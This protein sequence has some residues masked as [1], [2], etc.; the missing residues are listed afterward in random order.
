MAKRTM[1]TRLAMV[2]LAAMVGAACAADW[3]LSDVAQSP[4]RIPDAQRARD[5]APEQ[6]ITVASLSQGA[7]LEPGFARASV[8]PTSAVA[9]VA[10]PAS[11]VPTTVGEDAGGLPA[12][13]LSRLPGDP[14]ADLGTI[15]LRTGPVSE[16]P[17]SI[18]VDTSLLGSEFDFPEPSLAPAPPA[19]PAFD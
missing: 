9:I 11:Q 18:T 6:S 1:A 4:V 15:E 8:E 7:I 2:G 3:N 10:A 14:L 16:V 5:T 12:A 19:A 17:I 13:L